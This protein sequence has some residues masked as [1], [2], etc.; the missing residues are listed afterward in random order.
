MHLETTV[1]HL[2]RIRA[3]RVRER[4]FTLIELMV[5]V[6]IIG[7]L[8][9][10]AIPKFLDYMKKGKRTEAEVHLYAIA[11][12]AEAEY[13]ETSMFPQVVSAATPAVACC[14]Q[15]GKKCAVSPPEWHGVPAWDALGFE[16][17]QPYYFQYAYASVVPTDYEAQAIGDLDC[18]GRFIKFVMRGS[19]PNGSPASTLIKPAR[20]D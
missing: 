7:V 20:A 19:A 14:D 10:V 12:S 6:A 4:G 9:A 11:K 17:T 15:P 3:V 5:V 2:A 1:L 16:M 8:S 13:V 18:D